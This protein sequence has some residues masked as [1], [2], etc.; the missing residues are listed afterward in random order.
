LAPIDLRSDTV[1]Q[2]SDPMRAAM[3]HAPVGDDV[4]GEDPTARRLEETV[5]HLLGHDAALFVPSGTMGNQIAMLAH[6]RRGDDVVVGEGAHSVLYESGGGGA[7]AGVQFTQCGTGGHFDAAQLQATMHRADPSGHVAPTTL[8]MVENTHNRGGGLVMPPAVFESISQVCGAEDMALHLDGARLFNAAVAEGVPAATW[9]A[10]ADSVTVCLSK[11]LGAPVGSVLCGSTGFIRS[12]HRYRKMLGGGMRQ[13]G[14]LAA[15]G[16]YALEHH[17]APLAE[18]HRRAQALAQALAACPNAVIEPASV[19]TNIVIFE[20]LGMAP[21]A[22]CEAV[23]AD[24][25]L[26][27]F[28]PQS[29]RAVFHRDVSDAGLRRTIAALQA[30]LG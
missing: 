2:P 18:D 30:V 16:L 21:K 12:A 7:L 23:A 25:L 10:A 8:V 11:G 17:L 24:A 19:R 13:I 15:A 1:T 3:H 14:Q 28:G 4:F 6:C 20:L 29:V 27:P 9:A 22:L 5:A 26:L